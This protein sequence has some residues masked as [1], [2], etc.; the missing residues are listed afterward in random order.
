MVTATGGA[1]EF[2]RIAQGLGEH[3]PETEF[4]AGLRKFSLPL[5]QVAGVLTG[6]IF[7]IN[8]ALHKPV[9]DALLFSLSIAVGISPQLLPAVVS[10]SPRARPN[11][12]SGL[13]ACERVPDGGAG[14]SAPRPSR[15]RHQPP[16]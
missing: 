13:P 12:G 7:I 15:D 10:T 14:Q 4:Q 1:A 5:V 9:I 11:R 3:Q 8:V 2:G 16:P 6:A